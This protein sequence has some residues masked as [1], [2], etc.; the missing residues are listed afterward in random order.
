MSPRTTR[1][2]FQP[3][4]VSDF[5]DRWHQ[6]QFQALGLVMVMLIGGGAG[7][8]V[9]RAG[10]VNSVVT[11]NQAASLWQ[12]LEIT[13]PVQFESFLIPTGKYFVFP[14]I[15]PQDDGLL[16][17]E[18]LISTR[19][20]IEL[21]SVDRATGKTSE[22]GLAVFIPVLGR[23]TLRT[24]FP[25]HQVRF[26]LNP[27]IGTIWFGLAHTDQE[28]CTMPLKRPMVSN[29]NQSSIAQPDF[30]PIALGL[31]HPLPDTAWQYNF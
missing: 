11:S 19:P 3:Q 31:P 24:Q 22:G 2:F 23:A 21:T 28:W 13:Q 16:V 20:G 29:P 14:V 9:H 8:R 17:P 27:Q 7:C 15:E 6:V 4:V 1:Q 12:P 30:R 26:S 5:V 25:S 10:V 18:I